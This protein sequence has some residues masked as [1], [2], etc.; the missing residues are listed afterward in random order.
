MKAAVTFK[1]LKSCKKLSVT[2][3]NTRLFHLPQTNKHNRVTVTVKLGHSGV[4][5]GAAEGN[6]VG[7]TLGANEG[8]FVGRK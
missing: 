2:A 3:N 8:G 7:G 6:C 5:A 1:T 4:G